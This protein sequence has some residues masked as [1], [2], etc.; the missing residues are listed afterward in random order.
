MSDRRSPTVIVSRRVVPGRETE[1]EAWMRRLRAAAFVAPGHV[2]SEFQ[3]PGPSHPDDWIVVYRFEDAESRTAWLESTERRKLIAEGADLVLGEPV[4]QVLAVDSSTGQP[5]TAVASIRIKPGREADY[6][7][8]HE[9]LLRRLA[10]FDGYLS[11]TLYEA[12]P[13]VQEETIIVFAF[14][15]RAGLDAWL[16][17]PERRE[18]L[19]AMEPLVQGDRTINVVGGF[20]G[21]F[22]GDGRTTVK[23]WKQSAVVLLA[24]FPTA[25]TLTLLKERFLPNIGLVAGVFL[26]NLLGVAIL[27]W[28]LMPWLTRLFEPWLRR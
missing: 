24:L 14:Q 20:A 27:G 26:G 19:E 10:Q 25:L 23:I 22:P 7:V 3:P 21:W 5:V 1:F 9:R 11:S 8:L 12:V 18:I 13:G 4:E 28:I 6:R 15:D 2:A 16:T 17:S